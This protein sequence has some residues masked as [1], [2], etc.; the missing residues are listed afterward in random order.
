MKLL[1]LALL[2]ITLYNSNDARFFIS[3]QLNN[4]SEVIRPDPQI[5]VYR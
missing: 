2:G 4:V 1:L 5:K 3:N